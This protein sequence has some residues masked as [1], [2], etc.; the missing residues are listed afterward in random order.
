MISGKKSTFAIKNNET[1]INTNAMTSE[2]L[3]VAITLVV[4][5]AAS[6]HCAVVIED[7]DADRDNDDNDDDTSVTFRSSHWR[8][9]IKKLFLKMS[10]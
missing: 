4:I 9:S 2:K 3:C 10:Q 8:C 6:A 5:T 7:A 1:Y